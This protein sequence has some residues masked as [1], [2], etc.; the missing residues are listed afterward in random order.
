MTPEKMTEIMKTKVV[1][2]VT[3][4]FSTVSRHGRD[5]ECVWLQETCILN[6]ATLTNGTGQYTLS[7]G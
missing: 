6:V 3:V 5:T 7:S 1:N 4:T 2:V